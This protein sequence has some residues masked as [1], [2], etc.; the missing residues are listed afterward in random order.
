[1]TQKK[2]KQ[3]SQKVDSSFGT[4]IQK[5]PLRNGL[6]SGPAQKAS[7]ATPILS[8]P[9]TSVSFKRVYTKDGL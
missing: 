2:T 5:N 9:A 1:M 3:G 4:P 8:R 6:A 7:A